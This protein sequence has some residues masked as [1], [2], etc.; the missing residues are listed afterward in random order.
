VVKRDPDVAGEGGSCVVTHWTK[1]E[2]EFVRLSEGVNEY[3]FL[4]L[5]RIR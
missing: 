2:L 5:G 4:G 1:M 3:W